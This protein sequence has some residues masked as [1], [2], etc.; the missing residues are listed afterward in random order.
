MD[1]KQEIKLQWPYVAI[2]AKWVPTRNASD[3]VTRCSSHSV[4]TTPGTLWWAES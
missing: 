2:S 3:V 1:E 4:H